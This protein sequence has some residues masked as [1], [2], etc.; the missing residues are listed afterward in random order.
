VNRTPAARDQAIAARPRTSTS[1]PNSKQRVLAQ[2]NA[3]ERGS[4]QVAVLGE[5]PADAPQPLLDLLLPALRVGLAPERNLADD[6]LDDHLEQLLLARHVRVERRRPGAQ[7]VG[8]GAH[9]H[10]VKPLAVDD[11]QSRGDDRLAREGARARDLFGLV[12]PLL[13]I[14]MGM[15]MFVVPVFDTI[16]A[17]VTDAETGSASG[18]L[19]AIQQLGAGI[20]VA[21]L[22]TIFFSVLHHAGFTAALRHTMW[23]QVGVIG[24]LL[25][26]SPLLPRRARE[27]TP[28]TGLVEPGP[29]VETP[30]G[31]AA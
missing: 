8:D 25:L 14:G 7:R 15:G 10:R 13:V 22:G 6:L 5:D 11:V 19:N 23:W 21:V 2:R 31:V 28:A 30:D 16:I 26:L 3:G 18:A 27:P 9:G 29:A 1:S 17:A 4:G 24:L 12:A 20:G